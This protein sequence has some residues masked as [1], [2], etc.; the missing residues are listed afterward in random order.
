LFFAADQRNIIV[1][2]IIFEAKILGD[3]AAAHTIK[4]STYM[5]Y[6]NSSAGSTLVSLR[7]L[8]KSYDSAGSAVEVLRNIHLDISQGERVAIVG[9]SGSG[10]TTLI[11]LIT[12]IDAPTSG[13]IIIQGQSIIKLSQNAL[14]QWRGKNIG[15]VFQFFQL[16]PTL[17]IQENILLPMDF[18]NQ[19]S[20]GKRAARAME[21]LDRVGLAEHAFKL[22]A[23]LSG[24]QQQRVAIARAMAND[25]PLLVADEPTGNLDSINTDQIMQLFTQLAQ[26]GKTII[27]VSHERD[28]SQHVDRIITVKDGE[29]VT[30]ESVT[31]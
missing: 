18:C 16:I 3:L 29:I 15:I 6:S 24:G 19:F 26:E 20:S 11:N 1:P 22:P 8:S 28:I 13:D 30:P 25:P 4:D 9:K 7:N 5:L 2:P 31:L 27:T 21:L 12:G 10:K 17:N 14:A 23:A